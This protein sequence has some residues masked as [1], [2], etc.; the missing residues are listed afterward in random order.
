MATGTALRDAACN[1]GVAV[2]QS[3]NCGDLLGGA[4]R[5]SS[6]LCSRCRVECRSFSVSRMACTSSSN[7]SPDWR[8]AVDIRLTYDVQQEPSR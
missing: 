4:H 8:A 2:M 3:A 7:M 1:S 5:S 6:S